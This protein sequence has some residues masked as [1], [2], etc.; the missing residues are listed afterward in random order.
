MNTVEN[1]QNTQVYKDSICLTI[2]LLYKILCVFRNLYVY[3]YI[4]STQ[5]AFY[6][7]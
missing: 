3:M 1:V 2:L 7:L 4:V 5:H 6:F